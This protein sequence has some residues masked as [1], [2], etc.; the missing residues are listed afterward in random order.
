MYD[1]IN[2]RIGSLNENEKVIIELF[3]EN[4]DKKIKEYYT[5]LIEEIYEKS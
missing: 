3:L 4:D 2:E 5:T 1:K